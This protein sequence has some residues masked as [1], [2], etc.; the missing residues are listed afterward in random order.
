MEIEKNDIIKIEKQKLQE[1]TGGVDLDEV[2]AQAPRKNCPLC[3]SEKG[4][5]IYM[6]PV[7][8]TTSN[9]GV[10]HWG[11]IYKCPTCNRQTYVQMG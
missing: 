1:V 11:Y 5:I 2:L 6:E 8:Y 3:C 9:D 10:W 4:Y 7:G